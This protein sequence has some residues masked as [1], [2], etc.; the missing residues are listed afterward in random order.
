MSP[1]EARVARNEVLSREVNERIAELATA[2]GFYIVCE[3]ANTGC[4]QRLLVPIADY[5]R[6][7]ERLRWFL[8]A[9]GHAV[10][11]GEDVVEQHGT[12]DVVEK[13]EDVM[14]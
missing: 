1:R 13:H 6:V 7:R 10:A 9:P 12:Y 5:R 11:D 2:E 3:C 8:I 14:P 4:D